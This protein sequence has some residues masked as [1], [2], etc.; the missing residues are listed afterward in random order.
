MF[1]TIL[2]GLR[3]F[4]GWGGGRFEPPPPRYAADIHRLVFCTL[5]FVLS[6]VRHL[7]SVSY[8]NS[9]RI[10][11]TFTYRAIVGLGGRWHES[12]VLLVEGKEEDAKRGLFK[13]HCIGQCF[14]T[15][16]P[17]PG[18]GPW[19]QLYWAARDSPGICHFSFLSNFS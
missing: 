18:N 19:H 9:A 16:G 7:L 17:R 1:C 14:S 13:K 8:T 2:E 10:K 15:A 12:F 6:E 4:R 5:T 3:N 11:T